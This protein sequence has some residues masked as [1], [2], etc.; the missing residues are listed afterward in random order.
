LVQGELRSR[1]KFFQNNRRLIRDIEQLESKARKRDILVESRALF[2]FYEHVLPKEV[3]SELD[4][5]NFV[6]DSRK[7]AKA[8]ELT[9]DEL[10]R[11]EAGLSDTLYPN[12]LD[13]GGA[14]LP[15]K[16][17]FEPGNR[18]DGVSVDVPL[19]LLSQIPRAQFD[20]I[21]PGL[22]EEKCLALIRSLPKSVRK[23]FVPAPDYVR[24]VLE[25]F[26]Y[27]GKPL[28]EALADRL[29]RLSGTRVDPADFRESN[30]ERHLA[31]NIRVVDDGGKL[32]ASGRDFDQLAEQLEGKVSS[33]LKD[34]Q[35]HPLE[36]EGLT[37]WVFDELPQSI[38]IREGGVAVT[39]YPALCDDLDS[40][41]VRLVETEWKAVSLSAAGLLRLIMFQLK[42]QRKY[43]GKNIPDFEQ[44]SLYFATRGSRAELAENIVK[45]A[46]SMTFVESMSPV[47]SRRG[48][49]ERLLK[50]TELYG[51][52]ERIAK[53]VAQSL[54]QSLAVE[55]QLKTMSLRITVDDVRKQ[56]DSLI[57]A[58]FPFGI[59]FDWL[60]QYPRYF[61]GIAH[62]LEKLGGN[63]ENDS[64]G[65]QAVGQWW[66]RY[67]QAD[68]ESREKLEKFRWMLEEYRISLFAQSIGTTMPVSEKRLTKEWESVMG[69]RR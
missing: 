21:V 64:A 20:W 12:R 28:V 3:C 9:R 18:D 6:N 60:R 37:D 68:D 59:P 63:V 24:R 49:D 27:E 16:Y 34:R 13:V 65:V 32:V 5:R 54:Q 4:L 30:L 42:D 19:V 15:L 56:L 66:S 47:S 44:F 48:F 51:H 7:N 33:R 14:S 39:M 11:R 62:R 67:E 57:P 40:V 55:G 29:F 36:V 52:L 26:D 1:L 45:A 25:S 53:V 31:L 10:M 8:M 50:K 23:K 17:K 43:L 69:K 22:L 58:G 41:S 35:Q 2:D 61:R 38:Q 46:F